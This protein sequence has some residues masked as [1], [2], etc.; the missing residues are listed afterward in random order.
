MRLEISL[1]ESEATIQNLILSSI[2]EHINEA[3]DK[4]LKTLKQSI[5]LEI[6]RAITSEPEYQSLTGGVLLYE[7]GIPDA[8]KK[9]NNIVNIWTN[10]FNIEV[11]PVSISGS[12]ITGG[13]SI[14]MI[15]ENYEDVLSSEDAF[16][17]DDAKSLRLPWL[18]WLLLY[19]GKI[20]VRNYEVQVGSN[21]NSRTGL[22]IM[23]P[24]KKNW[25]VPP[26]FSGTKENNW[27]TRALDKLDESI[28]LLIQK[29]IERN[30]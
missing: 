22:A 4:A 18:E 11:F 12:R 9:V 23:K 5:P 1:L 30:I 26:E 28:P 10:N 29:E 20:I 24:S 13:F 2:I 8:S 7:L 17:M 6:H 14:S 21:P 15:K 19:G 27:V 16:V 3:F 25:R